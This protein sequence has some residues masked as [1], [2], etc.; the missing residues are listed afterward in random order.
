[1]R[2]P[3]CG[4]ENP[5]GVKFCGECGNSLQGCP[6]CGFSN[7]LGTKFYH[8]CGQG[9]TEATKQATA[10]DPRSYTPPHLAEK[11]LRE[12]AAL[13]GERRTVTVLFGD[14]AGFTPI[15]ERLDEEE[16]YEL[17]QGCLGRM[18]DA[19]HR[20]EGTVTQFTGDGVL[21]L[22]GVT[23]V[24][25]RIRVVAIAERATHGSSIGCCDQWIWSHRKKPSQPWSS[26]S[27]ASTASW[28][29]SANAPKL[30]MVIPKRMALHS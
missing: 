2:C 24:P 4:H 8:E 7:P 6:H 18:M 17:M 29:T 23:I 3:S 16:V 13:E 22:F 30:G 28:R 15:S 10:T 11:I 21:A 27:L 12:R 14:A 19:I 20:Y 5:D 25:I 1:M 9:L 26:A